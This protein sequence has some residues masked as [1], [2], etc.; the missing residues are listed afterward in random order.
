[1]KK[2]S[3]F[4]GIFI[5]YLFDLILVITAILVFFLIPKKEN[6]EPDSLQFIL[7]SNTVFAFE[8][9]FQGTI[10]SLQNGTNYETNEGGE[11]PFHIYIAKNG[12]V[13]LG[14]DDKSNFTFNWPCD[15]E[16]IYNFLSEAQKSVELIKMSD[17][18]SDWKLY[19]VDRKSASCVRFMDKNGIKIGEYWFGSRDSS[20]NNI[21][22][23]TSQD[24]TIWKTQT[25]LCDFVFYDASFW[26]DPYIEPVFFKED[27]LNQSNRLRRGGLVY[28][29]PPADAKPEKVI[30]RSLDNGVNATYSFFKRDDS[31]IVL[32]SFSSPDADKEALEKINYR[33]SLSNALYDIYLRTIE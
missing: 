3:T 14:S 13:W 9:S 15:I 17:N 8:I 11:A 7:D 29:V 10:Q 22:L 33:F 27:A 6:I 24:K 23:R 21:F 16:K 18:I 4:K 26:A 5:F 28:L 19:S 32:P 31:Y 1:M 25:L 30:T 2:L 12:S 20:L